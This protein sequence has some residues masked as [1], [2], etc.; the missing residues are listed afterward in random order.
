MFIDNAGGTAYLP[1]DDS[2]QT[3]AMTNPAGSVI[4]KQQGIN[5]GDWF[6]YKED[7]AGVGLDSNNTARTISAPMKLQII[8]TGTGVRLYSRKQPNRNPVIIEK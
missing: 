1:P 4:V 5:E 3:I 6:E 8:A 2:D 7:G